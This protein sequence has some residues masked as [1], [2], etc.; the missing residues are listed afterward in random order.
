[1]SIL[2]V[3]EP[4][5]EAAGLTACLTILGAGGI[6]RGP[7]NL[8]SGTVCIIRCYCDA[9]ALTVPSRVSFEVPSTVPKFGITTLVI[10]SGCDRRVMMV[11]CNWMT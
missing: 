5:I 3:L 11:C 1:M 9:S 8:V 4:T 6:G 2:G 7:K 10:V